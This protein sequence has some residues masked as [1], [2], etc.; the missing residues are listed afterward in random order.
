MRAPADTAIID[1]THLHNVTYCVP[2]IVTHPYLFTTVLQDELCSDKYQVP[3]HPAYVQNRLVP[4]SQMV[5]TLT[6]RLHD[7]RQAWK[8]PDGYKVTALK[9][10][11]VTC[12]LH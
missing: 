6:D 7:D 5:S 11:I 1:R 3:N 2:N 4:T 10:R 9:Y 12:V 8:R